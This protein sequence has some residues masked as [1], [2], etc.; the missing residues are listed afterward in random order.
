[1]PRYLRKQKRRLGVVGTF[2]G[3]GIYCVNPAEAHRSVGTFRERHRH[4]PNVSGNVVPRARSRGAC[5][6]VVRAGS[7]PGGRYA[8]RSPREM[9]SR[10]W[11]I[12]GKTK[13]AAAMRLLSVYVLVV[14]QLS[15]CYYYNLS[16][17]T[18]F[19]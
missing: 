11:L 19:S 17:K 9:T 1:M 7:I 2:S 18:F 4:L 5:K 6:R 10:S 12:I 13:K 3:L 8:D 16:N 15:F 14:L